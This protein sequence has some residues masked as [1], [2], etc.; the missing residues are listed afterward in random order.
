MIGRRLLVIIFFADDDDLRILIS[1]SRGNVDIL[2]SPSLDP[3]VGSKRH[4]HS[5]VVTPQPLDLP[6]LGEHLV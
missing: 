2:A 6:V 1:E 3:A 5:L 4:V